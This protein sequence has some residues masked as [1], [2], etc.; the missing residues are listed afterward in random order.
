MHDAR[1]AF[2]ASAKTESSLYQP[3]S[4]FDWRLEFL[5]DCR[6]AFFATDVQAA[7]GDQFALV[8]NGDSNKIEYFKVVCPIESGS[9][10]AKTRIY[11][12]TNGYALR[13]GAD[14]GNDEDAICWYEGVAEYITYSDQ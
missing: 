14:I 11:T 13:N 4:N 6:Q 10:E 3:H 7:E 1:T 8:D 5:S 9:G 12:I 2:N